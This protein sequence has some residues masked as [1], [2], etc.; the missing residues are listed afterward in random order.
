MIIQNLER[1]IDDVELTIMVKEAELEYLK[2]SKAR[3]SITS[4][5]AEVD[6]LNQERIA[7]ITAMIPQKEEEVRSLKFV[8]GKY[9]E[10]LVQERKNGNIEATQS[11]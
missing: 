4:D 5:N 7:Q 3:F 11:S 8:I 2:S 6:K 9:C 10:R 1:L